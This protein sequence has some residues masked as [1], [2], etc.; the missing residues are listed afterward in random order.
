VPGGDGRPLEVPSER[1]DMFDDLQ[2][3]R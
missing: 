2:W 1:Y 3:L